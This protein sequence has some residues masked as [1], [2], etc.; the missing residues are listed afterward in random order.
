MLADVPRWSV[1]EQL[2]NEKLALGYYLSGHPYQEYAA[3]LSHFIKHRLSD[4]T[5]EKIQPPAGGN[6]QGRR[7]E[8]QLVLAGIVN[9]VRILQTRRGK[10]AV[11]TLDDGSAQI[12]VMVFNDVYERNRTWINVDELLVVQGR[13]GMDDYSGNMRVSADEVF[14]LAS[15]RSTFARRLEIVVSSDHRVSVMRLKELLSHPLC[16]DGKCP[17][18]ISFR[19]PSGSAQLR[20]GEEW[21]VTLHGDLLDGLHNLLGAKNVHID[22]TA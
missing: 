8:M 1:R 15:A 17:V 6:G 10:M 11:V 18:V 5:P 3:E 16:R 7:K 2:Q 22:Y 4:I 9:N 19:N 21:G 13:A 20:L 12:E 14:D